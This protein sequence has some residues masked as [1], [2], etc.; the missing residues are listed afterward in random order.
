MEFIVKNQHKNKL[1]VAEMRML[2]VLK[3]DETL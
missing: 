1:S 3:L 2:R